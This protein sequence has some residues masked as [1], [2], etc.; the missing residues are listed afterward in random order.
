MI[1]GNLFDLLQDGVELSSDYE[2]P[3]RVPW[4]LIDGINVSAAR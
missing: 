4:A 3:G 1:A 2:R